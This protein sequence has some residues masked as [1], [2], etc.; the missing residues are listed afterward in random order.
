MVLQ[1]VMALRTRAGAARAFSGWNAR[2]FSSKSRLAFVHDVTARDGLQNESVV[3]EV[4]EKIA[5]IKMI[6]ASN[7]AS[8][9]VCSFVKE[10]LV[11]AMKDSDLLCSELANKDWFQEAKGKGMRFMGLVPN[12][13]GYENF[14]RAQILDT[15]VTMVSCTESHSKANVRVGMDDALVNV[16][17]V[18]EHAKSGHHSVRAYASMAF[19]CPFEGDVSEKNVLKVV[20]GLL[21]GNPEI[22]ILADTLG[23]A[24]PESV[25]KILQS[26]LKLVPP[27][28][29]GLHMHDANSQAIKSIEIGI[30][31]GIRNLD[32]S[33]GGLGGCNFAPGAKGN[34]S[35]IPVLQLLDGKHYSHG[36]DPKR[37]ISTVNYLERV[38][39]IVLI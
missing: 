16:K 25:E 10:S 12:T 27:E 30:D 26:V 20:E 24:R 29:I 32:A 21:G 17:Q 33:M 36:M 37:V 3:L 9:E 38:L 19:G 4:E 8:V 35:T 2:W 11:P 39:N 1:N 14:S 31:L 28:M 23:Q 15:V 13:R 7:P 5:L 18:M 6:V 22:V 34:I